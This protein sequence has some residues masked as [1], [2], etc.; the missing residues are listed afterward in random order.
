M[1]PSDLIF[2][3]ESETLADCSPAFLSQVG[4]VVTEDSDVD[5]FDMHQMHLAIFQTKHAGLA[6]LRP[7]E[8]FM[9]KEIKGLMKN[10]FLPMIK[11][12]EAIETIKEWPLWNMKSLILQFYRIL[13]S[14]AFRLG[15][16]I[17]RNKDA[18]DPSIFPI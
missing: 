10:F 13:N 12:I 5:W 11:K 15:E 14:M 4:I 16:A 1:L 9:D 7:N 18:E 3:F 2:F 8:G 17:D 6:D